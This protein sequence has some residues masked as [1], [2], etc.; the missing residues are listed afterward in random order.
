MQTGDDS[1]QILFSPDAHD[2]LEF[3]FEGTFTLHLDAAL[4]HARGVVVA[5]LATVAVS[6]RRLENSAENG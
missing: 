1:R 6:T 3:R 4:V 2:A 5:S